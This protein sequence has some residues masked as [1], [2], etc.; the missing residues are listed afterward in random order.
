MLA[1]ETEVEVQ[2]KFSR[3]S[4]LTVRHGAYAFM[5][6]LYLAIMNT[7]EKGR[8]QNDAATSKLMYR[9]SF[10]LLSE[11]H[12]V[13]TRIL[14]AKRHNLK[15]QLV[16]FDLI[17]LSHEEAVERRIFVSHGTRLIPPFGHEACSKTSPVCWRIV[18]V[19]VACF[20]AV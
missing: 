4:S 10:P 16:L 11:P 8:S 7:Q 1:Q 20:D 6:R 9:L 14:Q 5:Y 2:I 19:A 12:L 18:I 13:F 3:P 17:I 15:A